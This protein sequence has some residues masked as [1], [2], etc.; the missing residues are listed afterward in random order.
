MKRFLA[1]QPPAATIVELQSQIDR[2]ITYYNEERPHRAKGRQ[3][4]RS[5]FDGRDKAR[6]AGPAI[7]VGSGVRV[8]YDSIDSSGTVTL[9][10]AGKLHHI[11]VGRDCSHTRVTM[12]ID[13][14]E[15]RILTQ[16]GELLRHFTLDPRKIYHGTGRPPGPPKG[17]HTGQPKKKSST[18]P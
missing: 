9:R 3:T 15:I 18:M 8:R 12:L 1:K 2:F 7:Q 4:P 16:K 13:G 5:A 6:P 17:R 10:H 11:G 14:M